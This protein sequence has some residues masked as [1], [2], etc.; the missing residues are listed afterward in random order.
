MT[1]QVGV[2]G[3]AH[4]HVSAYCDEWSSHSEYGVSVKAGWD[5]DAERV[6]GAAQKHGFSTYSS[7]DD[8]LS[9]QEIQAVV[10]GAE[11]SLHA[12]LAE[13]A[14]AKGKSIIL[15]KP[16]A[17]SLQEAD[18]IVYA[19][20]KNDVPFTMAWQMRVDPQN[21]RMKELI[22]SGEL[23][24][25]FMVRRRHGL[26]MGLMPDFENSWHVDSAKN[27]DIWADDAS[28]PIDFIQWMLGVPQSVTAEIQSLYNPRISMDNGIALFRYAEGP[29]AEVC[30]SFTCPASENTTE[31]ICEK[32]T[33][34]QNYGDATSCNVERPDTAVGLKW[35]STE[36]GRWTYSDINSPANHGYRIRGLAQPLADFLL[37]RRSPIATAEEGRASLRMLLASYVSVREGRR[38]SLT[39]EAI[40][41]V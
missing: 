37:G 21:I 30:C 23:G 38:I 35:Y 32:G 1:V 4:G 6:Q 29:L 40:A 20:A 28:H 7:V 11:T 24:K 15:Q 16:M 36:K 22:Q 18:R 31:I 9:D 19:V 5:H 25:V 2:L 26:S 39:E 34:V 33:I 14:A 17:L 13:Q 12:D 10:I 3:F 27:R 8:L 41:K